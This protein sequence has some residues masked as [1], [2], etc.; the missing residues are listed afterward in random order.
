MTS[1]DSYNFIG[2]KD[3][4]Y[5]SQ[6]LI[7]TVLVIRFFPPTYPCPEQGPP[8]D[9]CLELTSGI[10]GPQGCTLNVV[11]N[12]GSATGELALSTMLS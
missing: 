5:F 7:Y 2:E 8:V 11:N 12:G 3:A 4:L 10:V 1:I 6:I 9:I